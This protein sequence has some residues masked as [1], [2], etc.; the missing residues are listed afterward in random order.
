MAKYLNQIGKS[1]SL[2]I[3]WALEWSM[4]FMSQYKNLLNLLCVTKKDIFYTITE[5]LSLV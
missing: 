3:S 4:S 1:A 2:S 5:E